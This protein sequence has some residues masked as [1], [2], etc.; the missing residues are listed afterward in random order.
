MTNSTSPTPHPE[1]APFPDGSFTPGPLEIHRQESACTISGFY[2]VREAGKDR[3][4]VAYVSRREDAVLYAAASDMFEALRQMQKYWH[5]M[6]G[7]S[8]PA[9]FHRL[10]GLAEAAL[11]KATGGQHV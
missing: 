2:H 7:L 9:E 10:N 6:I 5:H 3:P 1:K 11:S 4:A 8:S